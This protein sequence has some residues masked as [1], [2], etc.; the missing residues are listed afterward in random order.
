[1]S[2]SWIPQWCDTATESFTLSSGAHE[3][4]GLRPT[5]WTGTGEGLRR[6]HGRLRELPVRRIVAAID[7]AAERWA[8]RDFPERRAAVDAATRVTG[9]SSETVDRALDAEVGTLRTASLIAALERELGD[10]EVLDGFRGDTMAI[11]PRTVLA[12]FSGNVPGLP[13]R[14]LVRALMVKSSVIAKIPAKEPG[15]T[16]AFLRTLHDVEPRLADAV[17]ATYWDR[18]DDATMSAALEQADAVIAYGSDQA[19][20]AIRAKVAPHQVYEEHGHKLSFGV[21]SDAYF[22]LHGPAEV[23]RRI[24]ADCS[25]FDQH[26]CLS[27]Q[28]YLV[29]AEH[30]R[31]VAEHVADAMRRAAAD[32]PPG[33]PG[34]H[35]ATVLQHRRLVAE[36]RAASSVGSEVWA[37]PGGLEWTVV[38]DDVLLPL[39]GAGNRVSRIVAVPDLDA[40]V[41]AM[42][43]Y[44]EHL[45]NVGLGAVGDEFWRVAG[46]LARVGVSRVAEPGAMSRASMQWRHDGQPRIAGLVRWCDVDHRPDQRPAHREGVMG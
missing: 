43:P 20:A 13:A 2:V 22:R 31:A 39:S 19:C 3:W 42:R 30:A 26:A 11:G 45:Q 1:M 40:A 5:D 7:V 18:D 16:A 21:I 37:A 27:P 9:M 41:D 25:D 12:V 6:A 29:V 33:T 4:R 24:A 38:L 8:K 34:N 32:C 44:A 46:E 28:V 36:W 17:V 23:A 14:S 15:F 10:P 35:D